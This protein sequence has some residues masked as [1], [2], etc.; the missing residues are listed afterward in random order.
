MSTIHGENQN[1]TKPV[2]KQASKADFSQLPEG[3]V[4]SL[5]RKATGLRGVFLI[6]FTNSVA[7]TE[8]LR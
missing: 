4:V 1:K 7:A 6:L 5:F 2:A 3:A 8:P